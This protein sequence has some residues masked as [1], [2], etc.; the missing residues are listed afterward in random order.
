MLHLHCIFNPAFSTLYSQHRAWGIEHWAPT[1]PLATLSMPVA[2]KNYPLH[3]QASPGLRKLG[4]RKLGLGKLT[5]GKI[6][7]EEIGS[8]GSV[9][10]AGH[11]FIPKAIG[12]T[13][14]FLG[15]IHGHI[16][17]VQ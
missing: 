1:S 6:R 3:F 11:I 15:S 4:L 9:V 7:V 2:C 8:L 17:P 14:F 5:L 16:S 10:V 12:V 13:A